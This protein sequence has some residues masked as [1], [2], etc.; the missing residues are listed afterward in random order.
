MNG[1]AFHLWKRLVIMSGSRFSIKITSAKQMLIAVS[2]LRWW[3]RTVESMCL[4]VTMTTFLRVNAGSIWAFTKGVWWQRWQWCRG[5]GIL[6]TAWWILVFFVKFSDY[7]YNIYICCV[8]QPFWKK[9]AAVAPG[10]K[11]SGRIWS[12]HRLLG[13]PSIHEHSTSQCWCGGFWRYLRCTKNVTRRCP[14]WS[15]SNDGTEVISIFVEVG[16]WKQFQLLSSSNLMFWTIL[17]GWYVVAWTEF[18]RWYPID[19]LSNWSK[20]FLWNFLNIAS[21]QN[22]SDPCLLQARFILTVAHRPLCAQSS[23]IA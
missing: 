22:M 12:C 3:H 16:F 2:R 4:G 14:S 15:T 17:C 11:L 6:S 8:A 10:T 23:A 9:Y 18:A 1:K 13:S 21:L 7:I 5:V 19:D 20:D